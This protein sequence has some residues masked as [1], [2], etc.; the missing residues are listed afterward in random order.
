MIYSEVWLGYSAQLSGIV[1]T[2]LG[3][4]GGWLVSGRGEGR[5]GGGREIV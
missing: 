5:G 3:P 1:V 2:V 4:V